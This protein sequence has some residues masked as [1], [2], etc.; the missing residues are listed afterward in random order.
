MSL[1]GI[2]RACLHEFDRP[3]VSSSH[4]YGVYGKSDALQ[5]AMSVFEGMT[6]IHSTRPPMVRHG[7][8]NIP[9]LGEERTCFY[10]DKQ[11]DQHQDPA[12]CTPRLVSGSRKALAV[13]RDVSVNSS[14]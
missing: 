4:Q 1:E 3:G 11:M 2:Q 14:D 13:E 6:Y 8:N 9:T 12:G 5:S 7:C 10:H